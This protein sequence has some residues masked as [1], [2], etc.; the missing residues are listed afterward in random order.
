[1]K[2]IWITLLLIAATL[3]FC[4]THEVPG[5]YATIQA[6]INASAN[7]DTVLVHP[8]TYHECINF[9][10]RNITVTSEFYQTLLYET[11]CSTVID[12]GEDDTAVTFTT[13]ETNAAHLE[14][15]TVC[16]GDQT[17]GGGIYINGASPVIMNCIIR[18]NTGSN[19]GAIFAQTS[20]AHI[21]Q[22]LFS[23]NHSSFEAGVLMAVGSQLQFINCV[24]Y[25]NSADLGA[26]A[27]KSW[28]GSNTL[29]RNCILWANTPN[30]ISTSAGGL[31]DCQY[32]CLQG[33]YAGTGNIS[34][35]P[36]FVS[37]VNL[38]FHLN[39]SSSCLNA[40]CPDMTGFL[41][42]TTDLEGNPRLDGIIDMG[43]FEVAVAVPLTA[44]FTASPLSGYAPLSVD[45]TDASTGNPTQW[46]WDF[47]NNG[48][49]ESTQPNPVW[50]YDLPGMYTV[51]LVVSNANQA[52][53]EIRLNYIN[54]IAV[55]A[56]GIINVPE[57]FATIQAAINA[58]SDGDTILVA[59]GNYTENINF[60]GKTITVGSHFLVTGDL[61][62][63]DATMITGNQSGSV[64]RF[65]TGETINSRL[66]GF[67]ISGGNA[68]AAPPDDSGGAITCRNSQPQLDN[69]IIAG[70]EASEGGGIGLYNSSPRI[71]SVRM[72]DN[73]ASMSGGAICCHSGSSPIIENALLYDNSAMI[74]GG[75]AAQVNSSPI[76]IN[77]TIVNN[78][79]DL[80][81]FAGGLDCYGTCSPIVMNCIFWGNT[82]SQI[83][84]SSQMSIT[85]SCIQNGQAGV[86]NDA[87]AVLNWMNGNI[88][89]NP[90]F[91][92]IV[93]SDF[94]L[95]DNS[96]CNTG[97]TSAC[98]FGIMTYFVPPY[99]LDM[100]MR[101]YP[102][103]SQPDMGAYENT[104][105]L[106]ADFIASQ[107][108]GTA[109]LTIQFTDTSMGFP[110]TWNWDFNGD[111]ITDSDQQNPIWTFNTPGIYTVSLTIWRG[112][113]SSNETKVSY[114]TVNPTANYEDIIPVIN[115]LQ[116]YPNPSSGEVSFKFEAYRPD[117][118]EIKIYNPK[119]QLVKIIEADK[120]DKTGIISWDGR[121]EKGVKVRPGLFLYKV[122]CNHDVLSGKLLL[123]K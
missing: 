51:R 2:I 101:P 22:C 14:G 73:S 122:R 94:H 52:D 38:D 68:T 39:T 41:L 102:P 79:T 48:V 63:I 67:T 113:A 74:G 30:Q 61:V 76:L 72:Y 59:P 96:L 9:M 42:P 28:S 6:A 108:T 17:M 105:P 23:G 66:S 20:Q 107:T 60:L 45:F 115:K 1:M 78:S 11:I 95:S 4:L 85:N 65:I 24:M 62:Y 83:V 37:P 110:D 3:C 112:V 84:N 35:D 114:I 117:V 5:S 109:P 16:H 93:N 119:G 120:S 64:V 100:V 33:G 19:G 58:S 46:Q 10:G 50:T 88:E 75:I 70:N 49:F 90:L 26:G 15:L 111:T 7:G 8:G 71:T 29:L 27:I 123:R 55:P 54:V 103:N 106:D 77:C 97:G 13:G 98:I 87:G 34:T 89:A 18:D 118:R 44:D 116:V 32:S 80:P 56:G 25:G 82:F 53:E 91:I 81:H 21:V 36:A 40:G 99:D 104:G 47:D 121:D 12:G 31:V 57:D 92:D 69:L 43:V 86:S